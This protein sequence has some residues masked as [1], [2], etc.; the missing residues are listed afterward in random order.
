MTLLGVDVGTT[1]AKAVQFTETGEVATVATRPITLC[2]P[3]PGHVELD[4]DEVVGSVRSAILQ[5]VASA[6]V[7]TLIAVTGQGDGC[8]LV[9]AD[10][11]PVRRAVNWMDGRGADA[12]ARWSRDG[13]VGRVFAHNGNA[14]FA[15]SMAPILAWLDEREPRSLDRATTAAYC[16]DVVFQ[17]LTGERATDNSDASL[18]FGNANG[19]GY[20]AEALDATGLAHRSALLA[21]VVGPLPIARTRSGFLPAPTVMTAGPFD[22]PAC[23]IGGGVDQPGDGLLI[24]GTTLGCQVLVDR[25]DTGSSPAGMHVATPTPGRWMRVMAA[26]SG[27]ASLDWVLALVG[28]SHADLDA[29]LSSSPPGAFGV[30]ILP[31]LAPSGERA[32]FVEPTA[33]G[34][35]TGLQLTSTRA[36]LVRATCEGLA[37]AAR[38]CF[39]AAGLSGRVV[40]CGGGAKSRPWLEIFATV[41]GRPLHVARSPEV[42]A[43]GA[44]MA[45]LGATA[46]PYDH[47]Q[48]TTPETVIDPLTAEISHYEEGYARFRRHHESA[49]SLWR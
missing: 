18:P 30:E 35:F 38:D 27:C 48:W 37:Y 19:D 5:A 23:A 32:P 36:D 13:T 33:H 31:Y 12:V 1:V 7:P 21:P 28:M 6:G 24:I 34:Q 2:H 45:A 42:G 44:V 9:D 4:I 41:L 26:M 46:T 39:A 43:R 15:G 20:A 25:I 10:A 40:V 11:R 49:R 8:W 3:R 17:R 16:K 47:H 22:L 29:A 14:L